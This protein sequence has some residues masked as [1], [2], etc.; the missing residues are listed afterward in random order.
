MERLILAARLSDPKLFL[1]HMTMNV[2]M[3]EVYSLELTSALKW[4]QENMKWAGKVWLFQQSI[5][6]T[7]GF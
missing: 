2:N 4:L 6:K 3:E 7:F 5:V 1:K